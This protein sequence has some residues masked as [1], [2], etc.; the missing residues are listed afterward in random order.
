MVV[1]IDFDAVIPTVLD[2]ARQRRRTETRISDDR[3]SDGPACL[4]LTGDPNLRR[5]LE[6]ASELAGWD[7]GLGPNDASSFLSS[8]RRDPRLVVVDLVTPADDDPASLEVLAG[9]VASNPHLL[10]VVCGATDDEHHELWA[11]SHGAFVHVPGVSAGDSIVSIF[12]EARDVVGRLS[13]AR[14]L[15]CVPAAG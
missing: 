13:S 3:P 12:R 4:V 14:R 6:A 9:R 11:R 8:F 7:T 15:P 2:V 1:A 10:L 5:R